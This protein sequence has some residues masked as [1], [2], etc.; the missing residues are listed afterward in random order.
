MTLR[1]SARVWLEAPLRWPR[2]VVVPA[3]VGLAAASAAGFVLPKQYRASARIGVES[4]GAP[5]SFSPPT[6]NVGPEQRLQAITAAIPSRSR[7]QQVVEEAGLYPALPGVS[8]RVDRLRGATEVRA[9]GP[10]SLEVECEHAEPATAALVAN[11]LA[12][13]FIEEVERRRDQARSQAVDLEIRL[14]EAQALVREKKARLDAGAVRYRGGRP[15]RAAKKLA[16]LEHV[17]AEALEKQIALADRWTAARVAQQLEPAWTSERF[18]VVAPARAPARPFSPSLPAFALAGLVA[19]L[20]LGL[21]AALARE[22]S[23]RSIKGPE[24]LEELLRSPLLATIP[25][26]GPARRSRR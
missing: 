10:D 1:P 21:F 24:D 15:A 12:A 19:G 16:A 22:H 4:G 13:L 3:L 23:D 14:A 25:Y 26:A 11:R 17:Y 20:I 5:G 7:L 18:R 6:A 9:L 8:A 2:F